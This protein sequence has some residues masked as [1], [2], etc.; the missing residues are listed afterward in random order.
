MGDNKWRSS[1]PQNWLLRPTDFRHPPALDVVNFIP[2]K[3]I[4]KRK[5]K[6]TLK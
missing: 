1:P 3:V 4:K 2:K 6:G 5:E